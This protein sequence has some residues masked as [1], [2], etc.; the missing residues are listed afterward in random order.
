MHRD[1]ID[2]VLGNTPIKI[3]AGKIHDIARRVT[4]RFRGIVV[5]TSALTTAYHTFSLAFQNA[6][7]WWVSRWLSAFATPDSGPVSTS[8]PAT[9]SAL[10]DALRYGRAGDRHRACPAPDP[11]R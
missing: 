7:Q 2:A 10:R 1:P 11:P 6:A 5:T 3:F 9:R 4:R 8:S